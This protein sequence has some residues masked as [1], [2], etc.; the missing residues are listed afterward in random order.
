MNT[1]KPLIATLT[2]RRGVTKTFYIEGLRLN[3]RRVQFTL[4]DPAY[5]LLDGNARIVSDGTTLRR[6]GGMSESNTLTVSLPRYGKRLLLIVPMSG[7]FTKRDRFSLEVTG[8]K[9]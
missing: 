3:S 5:R 8:G 9:A 7:T 1:P 2:N 6:L 4:A